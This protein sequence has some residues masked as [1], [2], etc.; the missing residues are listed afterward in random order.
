MEKKASLFNLLYKLSIC[1]CSFILMFYFFKSINMIQLLNN[2][3]FYPD[4]LKNDKESVL[5][6]FSSVKDINIVKEKL[7]DLSEKYDLNII[8]HDY[9]SDNIEYYLYFT[10]QEEL[11]KLPITPK[12]STDEFNNIDYKLNG[13]DRVNKHFLNILPSKEYYIQYQSFKNYRGRYLI[14]DFFVYSTATFPSAF[15]YEL[16]SLEEVKFKT[17]YI[18]SH[19]KPTYPSIFL[20]F[21]ISV[22]FTFKNFYNI[23][24]FALIFLLI[25]VNI[26]NK[27][28]K[29]IILKLHGYTDNQLVFY[30][31][32]DIIKYKIPADI[33]VFL[34]LV[35][36]NKTYM[37]KLFTEFII[38]YFMF[39]LLFIILIFIFIS[40][41]I[42]LQAK[43]NFVYFIKRGKSI[44]KILVSKF[45]SK[46]I[47][48][49][50]FTI[51]AFDSL[52]EFDEYLKLKKALILFSDHQNNTYNIRSKYKNSNP[53]FFFSIMENKDKLLELSNS[54]YIWQ[55]KIGQKY[56][57]R[58][59]YN[60]IKK[61]NIKVL[62]NS[63]KYMEDN[64]KNLILVTPDN[65]EWV[66]M[67]EKLLRKLMMKEYD[68][69]VCDY[70]TIYP[71]FESYLR[72]DAEISDSFIMIPIE[73]EQVNIQR[74]EI[75]TENPDK[76]KS[77][78]FKILEDD[79]DEYFVSFDIIY[80]NNKDYYI[81]TK[82]TQFR[83]TALRFI[84]TTLLFIVIEGFYMQIDISL[85]SKKIAV[86]RLLG[87]NIK[88][89]Y[90]S[91]GVQDLFII[92]AI[93]FLIYF[94]K[95][96]NYYNIFRSI[97]LILL[98]EFA[99]AFFLYIKAKNKTSGLIKSSLEE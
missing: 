42:F 92:I 3:N 89:I 87:N 45:I 4:F 72:E 43:E 75:V 84:L 32:K 11:D 66:K 22:F 52:P 5:I 99:I 81:S 58:V 94:I 21:C 56:I 95:G 53:Q 57:T 17:D 46:I 14:G 51:I 59:N 93:V 62:S 26:F 80:N 25:S 41:N 91:K 60:Y 27:K 16:E 63:V 85:Y 12:I 1:I 36:I 15:I 74:M 65:Y 70:Q 73:N 28:R 6:R 37:Y 69:L 7:I 54:T 55:E 83:E 39:F 44:N 40:L 68:I 24:I 33:L 48:T 29:F 35:F 79:I 96:M 86:N 2:P 67:N 31:F 90:I 82:N 64:W 8:Y 30:I 13:L 88:G 10:S 71:D 19:N 34:L 20:K 23:L 76:T 38:L 47:I 49:A 97:V 18:S 61:R 78:Y 77:E 98:I 9:E 50:I